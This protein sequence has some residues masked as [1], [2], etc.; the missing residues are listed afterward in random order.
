MSVDSAEFDLDVSESPS[1]SCCRTRSMSQGRVDAQAEGA[2]TSGETDVDLFTELQEKRKAIEKLSGDFIVLGSV[3]KEDSA[4]APVVFGLGD[5]ELSRAQ[6]QSALTE[7]TVTQQERSPS[8][9]VLQ[10]PTVISAPSICQQ[11]KSKLNLDVHSLGVS[12]TESYG[13]NPPLGG[14]RSNSF[15]HATPWPSASSP[16]EILS[17]DHIDFGGSSSLTVP[18]P[19]GLFRRASWEIPKICLH[20]MHLETLAA[21]EKN[22]CASSPHSGEDDLTLET[23]PSTEN[24]LS[25]TSNSD[26][27]EKSDIDAECPG[28]DPVVRFTLEG[29]EDSVS[30]VDSAY[31]HMGGAVEVPHSHLMKSDSEPLHG[32]QNDGKGETAMS[33]ENSSKSSP[34]MSDQYKDVVSLAVPVVKQRSTSMDAACLLSPPSEGS[35]GSP[36]RQARSRSVDANVTRKASNTLAIL[37]LVHQSFK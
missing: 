21:E 26:D 32:I 4:A 29:P 23:S 33:G 1:V 8:S 37:A 28:T 16:D 25:S 35:V 5:E 12:D 36:G 7:A 10:V 17:T 3:D 22:R 9:V 30:T 11:S 13:L 27:D 6:Q 20:C 34:S 15:D 24:S 18:K 31:D 2:V 14:R 19:A